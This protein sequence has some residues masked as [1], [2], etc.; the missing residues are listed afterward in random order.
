M[1]KPVNN[2]KSD[3]VKIKDNISEKKKWRMM[4]KKIEHRKR[5]KKKKGIRV[6]TILKT[7]DEPNATNQRI[8]KKVNHK[9]AIVVAILF[10]IASV[11]DVESFY[12]VRN[13]HQGLGFLFQPANPLG[14]EMDDLSDAVSLDITEKK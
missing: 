12:G 6:K 4:M 7:D 10:F 3:E 11:M 8:G 14:E 1:K 2:F 9:R 5:R 13:D